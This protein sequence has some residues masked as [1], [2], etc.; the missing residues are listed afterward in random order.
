LHAKPPQKRGKNTPK[1]ENRCE[2]YACLLLRMLVD[3]QALSSVECPDF[4]GSH[5]TGK[6]LNFL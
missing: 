4:D 2:H 3:L 1:K 6:S 5:T